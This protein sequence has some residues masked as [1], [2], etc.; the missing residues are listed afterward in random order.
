[1]TSKR[2]IAPKEKDEEFCWSIIDTEN[3]KVVLQHISRFATLDMCF[4]LNELDYQCITLL[5]QKERWKDAC[6]QL[7]QQNLN[8]IN[9]I[10][11]TCDDLKKENIYLGDFDICKRITEYEKELSSDGTY[12]G[13][14]VGTPQ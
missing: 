9:A 11:K 6:K 7:E 4:L 12:R 1:M 5:E 8:L 2:F 13:T 3:G 14:Q 10:V